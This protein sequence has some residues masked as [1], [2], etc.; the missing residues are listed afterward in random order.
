MYKIQSVLFP[1]H[2]YNLE[3]SQNWLYKN[4]YKI[5]KVDVKHNFLRYRQLNPSY[6]KRLG[7]NVVRTK[8]LPNKIELIIF[9]K[10]Y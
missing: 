2:L 7:Y 4:K 5:K 8:I 3:T 6:L 9:Y 1:T 10:D